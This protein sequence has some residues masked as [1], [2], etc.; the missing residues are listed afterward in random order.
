VKKIVSLAA[1]A[2]MLTAGSAAV[3]TAHPQL[4]M[5]CQNASGC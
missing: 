3:L 4:A 5:A 1:L 2:L